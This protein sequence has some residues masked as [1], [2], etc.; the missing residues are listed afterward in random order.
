M[1]ALLHLPPYCLAPLYCPLVMLAGCCV[2][3]CICCRIVLPRP[4]VLSL[5]QLV[6]ACP[7]PLLP[8][9]VVVL[10][11]LA[12][13]LLPYYVA[14]PPCHLTA[15]A[16]CYMLR[17]C[18]MSCAAL[19]VARL[20]RLDRDRGPTG[21]TPTTSQT[22]MR[23]LSMWPLGHDGING[24]IV[25]SCNVLAELHRTMT[26]T[27][28]GGPIRC[29]LL[30]TKANNVINVLDRVREQLLIKLSLSNMSLLEY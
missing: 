17:C 19:H 29:L 21:T 22:T 4:L 27:D 26:T 9:L 6:F 23:R 3:C 12:S 10:L 13:P 5:R 24:F 7:T 28:C 1:R 20:L 14:P 2:L 18:S 16:S 25:S 11:S 15:P 30:R 8:Y